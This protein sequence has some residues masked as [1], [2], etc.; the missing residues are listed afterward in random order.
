L[1][2]Y[3]NGIIINIKQTILVTLQMAMCIEEKIQKEKRHLNTNTLELMVER[4]KVKMNKNQ[5]TEPII[6]PIIEPP[7]Q[8]HSTQATQTE[9]I[10]EEEEIEKIEIEEEYIVTVSQPTDANSD[11]IE[12]FIKTTDKLSKKI[13]R[14]N[15]YVRSRVIIKLLCGFNFNKIN[16]DISSAFNNFENVNII[17]KKYQNPFTRYTYLRTWVWMYENIDILKQNEE[18]YQQMK[19]LTKATLE[20]TKELK[21]KAPLKAKNRKKNK[22]V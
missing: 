19:T 5:E 22:M 11:S 17:I 8:T 13:T 6:E 9:Y 10:E 15:H 4:L 3:T 20:D 1:T 21:L 14:D 16:G 18:L 2:K 12:S 7:T